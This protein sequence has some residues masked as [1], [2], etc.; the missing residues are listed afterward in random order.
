MSFFSDS[1]EWYTPP[2]VISRVQAVLGEIDLDPCSN[3]ADIPA[4]P[5][6]L[7]FTR[8]DDGLSRTWGGR[9]YMNPP[10]GHVIDAWAEKLC[11]EYTAGNVTEAIALVPARVDTDWFNRF[12]DAV[13]CFVDGRLKFSGHK[14][15]AP[16][17]SAVVYLGPRIRAFS[18]A[19][20][21]MGRI[22]IEL[23]RLLA[24]LE[25]LDPENPATLQVL[26][27]TSQVGGVIN[28]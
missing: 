11:S 2:E 27:E 1:D 18:S 19:F 21:D 24:A 7:H 10:Y 28:A 9:V 8:E 14:N 4:V 3:S 20:G 23:K 5:A 15:S 6:T 25:F 12:R 13:V 16:F 26:R 22:W 17:P